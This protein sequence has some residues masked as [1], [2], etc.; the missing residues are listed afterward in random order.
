MCWLECWWLVKTRMRRRQN[1]RAIRVGDVYCWGYNKAF[2]VVD[3]GCG[4]LVLARRQKVSM[5]LGDLK[6]KE[7]PPCTEGGHFSLYSGRTSHRQLWALRSEVSLS[8]PL[9]SWPSTPLDHRWARSDGPASCVACQ[10]NG[11]AA[12]R[13]QMPHRLQTAP[14]CADQTRG[15]LARSHNGQR[16]ALP[17]STC[18]T[19]FD[20]NRTLQQ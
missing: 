5:A 14:L 3:G 4:M 20:D 12:F 13:L 18:I 8:L 6:T 10:A 9:G 11:G 7:E 16:P 15:S 19:D 1:I 2:F 17:F